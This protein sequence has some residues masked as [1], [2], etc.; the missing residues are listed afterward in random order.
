MEVL[1]LQKLQTFLKA[2]TME[3]GS[4]RKETK[5][6]E[7]K[8]RPRRTVLLDFRLR[9]KIITMLRNNVGSMNSNFQKTI[10][11]STKAKRACFEQLKIIINKH[12]VGFQF[13]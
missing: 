6:K 1:I 4:K 12:I 13:T 3:V 2:T 9:A 11:Y 7:T 10:I 5:K 8:D